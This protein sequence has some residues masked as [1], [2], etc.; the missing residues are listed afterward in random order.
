VG[1]FAAGVAVE[2]G[3]AVMRCCVSRGVEGRWGGGGG[4]VAGGRLRREDEEFDEGADH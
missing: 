1:G 4:G 2:G 3:R